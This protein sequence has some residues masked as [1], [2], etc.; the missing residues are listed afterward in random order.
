MQVLN[1]NRLELFPHFVFYIHIVRHCKPTF[2]ALDNYCSQKDEFEMRKFPL[3]NLGIERTPRNML[4]SKLDM[5]LIIPRLNRGVLHRT[6]SIT[7]VLARQF[8]LRR[9]LNGQAQA[10]SP[11]TFCLYG[12]FCRTVHEG[13]FQAGPISL[14]FRGVGGRK[15]INLRNR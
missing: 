10:P 15:D 3:T 1:I 12:E 5:D 7:M 13:L 8:S 4:I 6:C 14:A 2:I 11:S 9:S